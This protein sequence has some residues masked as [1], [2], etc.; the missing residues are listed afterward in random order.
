MGNSNICHVCSKE[1]TDKKY[2]QNKPIMPGVPQNCGINLYEEPIGPFHKECYNI[3]YKELYKELSEL[4]K[5]LNDCVQFE[6]DTNTQYGF[7]RNKNGQLFPIKLWQAHTIYD[8][9]IQKDFI[10][11][12]PIEKLWTARW[13]KV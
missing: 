7:Y 5:P 3:W 11:Y 12:S 13:Q 9:I 6:R 4:D 10:Q 8:L 1:I 2:F